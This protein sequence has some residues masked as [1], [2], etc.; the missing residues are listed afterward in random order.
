MRRVRI[1]EGEVWGWIEDEWMPLNCCRDAA[2]R[3][4]RWCA[5]LQVEEARSGA[6]A[7]L[8]CGLLRAEAWIGELE[9]EGE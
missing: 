3:C 4:A 1:V 9:G 5:A 6:A 8:E 2:R 7:H